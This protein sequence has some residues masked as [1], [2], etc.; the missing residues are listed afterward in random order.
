LPREHARPGL[1]AGVP[2]SLGV[3]VDRRHRSYIPAGAV[4]R[5]PVAVGRA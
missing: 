5:A 3:A 2:G 4:V 1:A